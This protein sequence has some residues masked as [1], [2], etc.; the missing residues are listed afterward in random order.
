MPKNKNKVLCIERDRIDD[1]CYVNVCDTK[2]EAV[3]S[4]VNINND[5]RFFEVVREIKMVKHEMLIEVL[6]E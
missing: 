3:N 6:E 2:E 4:V 5:L 1:T